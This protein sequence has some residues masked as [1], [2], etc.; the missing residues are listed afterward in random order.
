MI[1]LAVSVAAA[2]A[3]RFEGCYLRPYLC[4]AGVPTI[5][6]GATYYEAA[7]Q[8]EEEKKVAEHPQQVQETKAEEQEY[9]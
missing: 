5:G 3:R 2:L 6:F 4:P 8:E 1:D 7:P 9:V